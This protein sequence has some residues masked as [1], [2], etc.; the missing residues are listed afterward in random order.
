MIVFSSMDSTPV[1]ALPY[2]SKNW[3]THQTIKILGAS[4][5]LGFQNCTWQLGTGN[6]YCVA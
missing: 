3:N 6:C 1:I 4:N 5:E 2:N